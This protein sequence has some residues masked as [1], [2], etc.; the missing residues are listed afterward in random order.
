MRTSLL[1]GLA[2]ALA[3]NL[4]RGNTDARLFEVGPIVRRATGPNTDHA[5]PTYA[6]GIL[7]GRG[8]GWL[9]PGDALDFFHAK[10]VVE[11][12][13]GGFGIAQPSY[14]APAGAP[15]FH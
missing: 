2:A 14:V 6:A 8:G 9:K 1:P 13:L 5:E 4:A 7:A 11:D 15:F 12:L 3:R 10:R